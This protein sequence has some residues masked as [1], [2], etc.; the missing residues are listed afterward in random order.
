VSGRVVSGRVVSGRSEFCLSP[1]VITFAN[2][3]PTKHLPAMQPAWKEVR[4]VRQ[5]Q[6]DTKKM[7]YMVSKIYS[8]ISLTVD[9]YL[10]FRKIQSGNEAVIANMLSPFAL[11]VCFVGKLKSAK[12]MSV[13]CL[14]F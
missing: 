4:Q 7:I 2:F 14:L 5:A 12:L 6:N 13:S 8:G 11:F 9:L 3:L 1:S 10:T